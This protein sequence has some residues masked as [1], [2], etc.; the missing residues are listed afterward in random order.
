MNENI[1][2]LTTPSGDGASITVYP[3]G[4]LTTIDS[5]L[6]FLNDHGFITCDDNCD[7]LVLHSSTA[8]STGAF[9]QLHNR[10]RS[11]Y[12]GEVRFCTCNEDGSNTL[13]RACTNGDLLWGGRNLEGI[14]SKG[15]NYIQYTN[16]LLVQYG[17]IIVSNAKESIV[18]LHIP[19][20]NNRFNIQISRWAENPDMITEV[21]LFIRTNT[22]TSFNIYCVS[23]TIDTYANWLT[24]G[25]WK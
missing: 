18:S 16:G 5:A 14:Y 12:P 1:G 8:N 21:P 13:F 19:Y 11:T 15:S 22:N 24:I 2:K 17:K 9:I 4:S 3:E 6:R 20:I 25:Y 10:N 23:A 7:G